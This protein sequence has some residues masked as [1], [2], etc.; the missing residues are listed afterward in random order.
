MKFPKN[1]RDLPCDPTIPLLGVYS[2]ELKS[3]CAPPFIAAIFTTDKIWKQSKYPSTD[4][5]LKKTWY[6][7]TIKYV[8]VLK[9]KEILPSM[10]EPIRCYAN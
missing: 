8:P 10:G 9:R 6:I 3:E 5:W 2:K 1:L 7:H 4:E